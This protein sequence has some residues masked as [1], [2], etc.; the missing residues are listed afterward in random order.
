MDKFLARLDHKEIENLN[1]PVMRKEV[2]LII[3]III[4]INFQ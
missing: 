1:I 3:I 4:I 2:E